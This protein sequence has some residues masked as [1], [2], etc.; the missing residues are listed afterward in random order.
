MRT[1]LLFAV[2]IALLVS[3][4]ARPL[5][6]RADEATSLSALAQMPI[7]EVTVFKDGHAFVLHQGRMPTDAAGQVQMDYLPTPVLGTFWPYSADKNIKLTAVLASQRKVKVEQTALSLRELI[8]ANLGAAVSITEFPV[9]Q[10]AQPLVYDAT[11]LAVPQRTGEELEKNSPPGAGEKLPQKGDVVLLKT[12]AGTK[13]VAINR[14]QDLTFKGDHKTL[15]ANEE[16]RNLLTLKLDWNGQ[17]PAKDAEVGMIY[18]QKG[19]RWIPEYKVTIDGQGT[20]VVKL[21]ATLI[22]ELADLSD[23]T[24]NLVIGVPTFALKDQLD[25]IALQQTLAQLSSYFRG[26]SLGNN[27]SNAVMTQ[28]VRYLEPP[29]ESAPSMNLGPDIAGSQK[30]EDLFVF[31]VKHITLKKGQ[32]MVLP[33]SEVTL[34]Y[35]DVFAAEIPFT[36]PPDVRRDRGGSEEELAKLMRAPKVMHKLRLA[37]KGEGVKAPLTTAPA[38][39]ISTGP[40]GD[41]LLAQGLMTYVSVGSDGDLTVTQAIDVKLKKT[42]RETGRIPNAEVWQNSK[43]GRVELTGSVT[44]TNYRDQAVTVEVTRYVLGN[45]TGEPSNGGRAEM[46]NVF[47]GDDF[48]PAGGNSGPW[49]AWWGWYGWPDWWFHFNG[50]GKIHWDVTVEPGKSLDLTYNWNYYCR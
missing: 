22:N 30:N 31:T 24:A 21:Q 15:A 1:P 46:V 20:A 25:P 33:V 27:F 36:P 39:I 14:L 48:A 43:Y 9:G 2:V 47:E 3:L 50:V 12:A 23:A 37:N 16:F 4:L 35:K 19:L 38:L 40:A 41:R 8:E 6:A 32:R 17:P 11:I 45:V 28:T 42:D 18:L 44:L 29:P 49:P 13:V 34:K 26:D 7:K 10:E 5:P